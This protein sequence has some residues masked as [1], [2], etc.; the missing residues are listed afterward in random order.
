M[1]GSLVPISAAA[2]RRLG[3][4]CL[5]AQREVSA[6]GG[7]RSSGGRG[8]PSLSFSPPLLQ[9]SELLDPRG[10][11]GQRGEEVHRVGEHTNGTGT[12]TP[13][14]DLLP[15][16]DQLSEMAVLKEIGICFSLQLGQLLLSSD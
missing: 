1:T 10:P 3:A 6:E 15:S 14:Q 13:P 8:E 12:P 4:G 2:K 11:P 16:W 5:A 9:E 7:E